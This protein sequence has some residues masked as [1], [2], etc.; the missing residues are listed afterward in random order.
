METVNMKV[1]KQLIYVLLLAIGAFSCTQEKSV[2]LKVL[3]LNT[4]IHGERVPGAS[5]GIVDLIDFTDPDVVL[6]CELDAGSE[7]PLT[8]Q[9]I[10][11]LSKRGKTYFGDGKNLQTG[12][13]SKYALENISVLL[14]TVE[15]HRPLV[16]AQITVNGRTAV[17]YSAHLD[18]M[19]YA[20][21]LPRGYNGEGGKL[22]V[23]VTHPDSILADNRASWRNEAI[24]GFLQEAEAEKAK[25]HLVII[26]G[27]FNEPSHLDWQE[28]T[29]D[30]RDHRGAVV[31][32]DVS[33]MLYEAG[34][35][36]VYRQLYPNAL[37]HPGFTWPAGNTSARLED[38]YPAP[39]ADERDRIDF[40]YYYPQPGTI[41][42]KACIVGPPASV[43]YGKI[44]P[45]ETDDAILTPQSI[46]P[47]DHKGNLAVFRISPPTKHAT[48]HP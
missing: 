46:W 19:H 22:D 42:V 39:D 27:D 30:I 45:D 41:P 48:S 18:H 3:Q 31:R 23:P 13:L 43:V 35:I 26:G 29:K 32:W 14:P 36:D 7:T 33:Q 9:L 47:S 28:D 20:P 38:L 2:D 1:T 25:G 15:R 8:Q 24:L 44:A 12:I 17:I 34:Y 5:G 21:Y 4:W 6:L 40:I 11:E 16:K 37:T 10:S